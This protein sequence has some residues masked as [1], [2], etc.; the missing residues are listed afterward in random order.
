MTA[1]QSKEF[2]PVTFW[3]AD[4]RRQERLRV[5]DDIWIVFEDGCYTARTQETYDLIKKWLPHM[6]WEQDLKE[7][8]DPEGH[9]Q[10]GYAPLSAKAYAEHTKLYTIVGR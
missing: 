3:L 6:A 7:P 9:P 8:I 1:A 5:D 2:T 10:T 4:P